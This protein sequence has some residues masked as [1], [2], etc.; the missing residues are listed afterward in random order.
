MIVLCFISLTF[1]TTQ[2]EKKDWSRSKTTERSEPPPSITLLSRSQV[3]IDTRTSG[4]HSHPHPQRQ[5]KWVSILSCPSD[6]CSVC[7][8]Q[9]RLGEEGQTEA[10]EGEPE[11]VRVEAR[12]A[13]PDGK[14]MT[15]MLFLMMVGRGLEN[16][17]QITCLGGGQQLTVTQG[18]D[19]RER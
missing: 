7:H 6:P 17:G 15:L 9:H 19:G 1:E 3:R 10:T 18:D 12:G 2:P 11:D 14:R 13:E 4:C 16:D 8:Q 5:S